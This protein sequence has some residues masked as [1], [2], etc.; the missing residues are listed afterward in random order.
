MRHQVTF[1]AVLVASLNFGLT[2]EAQTDRIALVKQGYLLM[3]DRPFWDIKVG[4]SAQEVANALN[5]D[6]AKLTGHVAS[7]VIQPH[8]DFPNELFGELTL[9]F[10]DSKFVRVDAKYAKGKT[11]EHAMIHMRDAYGIEMKLRQD[12]DTYE[13]RFGS[14]L[15]EARPGLF[16]VMSTR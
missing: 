12:R 16:V 9:R 14:I 13:A 7:V 2:S 4:M 15:F 5:L 6:E 3:L 10:L 8:P 11:K 1:V